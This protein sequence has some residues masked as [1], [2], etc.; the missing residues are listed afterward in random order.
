MSPLTQSK[1]DNGGYL[2]LDLQDNEIASIAFPEGDN[3]MTSEMAVAGNPVRSAT[4]TGSQ[5]A[6]EIGIDFLGI[7]YYDGMDGEEWIQSLKA[8][9]HLYVTDCPMDKQVP[10]KS[11]LSGVV[12][13]DYIVYTPKD[14]IE[15]YIGEK[16]YSVKRN[17]GTVVINEKYGENANITDDDENKE[18]QEMEGQI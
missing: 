13:D 4:V 3:W 16:L 7:G 8:G 18:L 12:L 9:T 10:L 11:A 1:Y 2:Y 17:N 15:K 14:E 5:K 6:E